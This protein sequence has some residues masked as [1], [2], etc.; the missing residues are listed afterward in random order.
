MQLYRPPTLADFLRDA[1]PFLLQ[2]EAE[3]GLM[4]GLA[5]ECDPVPVGAYWAN[6]R[7]G[8]EMVAAALGTTEKLILSRQRRPGAAALI[9]ESV[10]GSA[11]DFPGVLG[12]PDAVHE[13]AERAGGVWRE[14]LAHRIYECRRVQPPAGVPGACRLARRGDRDT[15]VRWMQE[16]FSEAVGKPLTPDTAAQRTDAH[17]SAGAL[18]VWEVGGEIVSTGSAV[19]PTPHGIRVSGVYTPPEQRGHGYASALTSKITTLQ[20]EAGRELVF[21]YTD[22]ANPV[23]NRIYQR[24]GYVPVAD[25]AE[26]LRADY[27][28]TTRGAGTLTASER[29]PSAPTARTAAHVSSS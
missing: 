10:V 20:L 29:A 8:G 11:I 9:A 13:F 16:F 7:D 23:S 14:G 26:R 19:A 1:S 5:A 21:L 3:H 28:V 2:Q 24:I 12:P 18:Y 15:V 4:L 6:V 22:L 17:Q 25:V 27:R